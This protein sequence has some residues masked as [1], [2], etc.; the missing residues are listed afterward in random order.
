ME[1]TLVLVKPDG[2]KR[3]LIGTII[4]R[5]EQRSLKVVALKMIKPALDHVDN[6]YPKDEAWIK[7]LGQKGF[8]SFAEMGMNPKEAM[9]TNDEHEAGKMVRE[10]L[11]DYMTEAPV[12]AMVVEGLHAVEMVRK[13]VG[14]TLPSKADIGTIRGD[15]SVDSSA[16]ANVAKRAIKNLVHAS[17][18]IDEAEHEIQHWFSEEEIYEYQRADESTMY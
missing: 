7:R 17:E 18:T 8:K 14:N 9:G 3:A 13:I 10:W 4:S 12:I 11:M 1:R 15:F 16:A 2:V 5:F 6:H